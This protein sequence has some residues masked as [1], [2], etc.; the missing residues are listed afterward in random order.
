MTFAGLFYGQMFCQISGPVYG[1]FFFFF[2][3]ARKNEMVST[4]HSCIS[5]ILEIELLSNL[6]RAGFSDKTLIYYN[7][8][9]CEL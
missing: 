1:F 8:A 7:Y 6:T 2:L 3:S 9:E 5:S 4:S